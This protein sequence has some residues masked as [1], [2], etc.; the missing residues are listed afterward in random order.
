MIIPPAARYFRGPSGYGFTDP[1]LHLVF[2]LVFD[3][4]Y[5]L[6]FFV[7][8]FVVGSVLEFSPF[9]LPTPLGARSI[10][11]LCGHCGQPRRRVVRLG[12]YHRV[13]GIGVFLTVRD[14]IEEELS[15]G[16]FTPYLAMHASFVP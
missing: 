16:L 15:R 11:P 6:L 1:G 12:P 13:V 9:L 3:H 4:F 14:A 7:L 8:S 2:R 5:F 10:L